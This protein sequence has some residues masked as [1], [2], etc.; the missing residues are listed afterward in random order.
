MIT[1]EENPY[2][3]ISNLD[4]A[5]QVELSLEEYCSEVGQ[6]KTRPNWPQLHSYG[7]LTTAQHQVVQL[8]QKW[9]LGCNSPLP[10]NQ[11][12]P[13]LLGPR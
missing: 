1:K 3:M 8:H 5:S 4:C 11:V 9:G 6:P 10:K 12:S 13:S 2:E 7:D